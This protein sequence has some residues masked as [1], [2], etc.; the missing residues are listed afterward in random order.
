MELRVPQWHKG[1]THT[2][3]T[4][5]VVLCSRKE[6]VQQ[7]TI[8]LL[9]INPTSVGNI[10]EDALLTSNLVAQLIATA[11]SC[12]MLSTFLI[13]LHHLRRFHFD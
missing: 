8:P 5:S 3:T 12:F 4:A 9:E 2:K 13:L 10:Y 6:F 11:I 1:M 7:N